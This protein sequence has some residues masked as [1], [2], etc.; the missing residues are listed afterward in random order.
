MS[1]CTKETY[2]RSMCKLVVH[3]DKSPVGDLG[4]HI[5]LC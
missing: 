2:D 4:Q 1:E 3:Y 5:Y